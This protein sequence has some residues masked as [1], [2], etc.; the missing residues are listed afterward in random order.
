MKRIPIMGMQVP[1]FD[2]TDVSDGD[3][4][5]DPWFEASMVSTCAPLFDDCDSNYE[6]R[7]K[8][9]A[10]GVIITAGMREDTESCAL[11]V[12]FYSHDAIPGFIDRLN[13]YLKLK[14]QK[15]AEARVF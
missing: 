3:G 15:L 7:D 12:N 2:V 5:M 11:V 10:A 14:A 13:T 6:V 9:E 8:L 4:S 1:Q